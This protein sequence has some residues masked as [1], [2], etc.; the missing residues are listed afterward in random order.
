[1]GAA[2]KEVLKLVDVDKTYKMG[3]GV[4]VRA[5][6]KANMTIYDKELMCILG[7]SGSGKSTL[8][9][10]IGLL[11]SPTS[12]ERYIDGVETSTMSENEQARVRGSKIGF[13]FQTF[14]LINSLTVTD[15]V[16]LPLLICDTDCRNKESRVKGILTKVG[17][18]HRM[19]HYPNQLSGGERQRV[20]IARALVNDPE[21]ILADEPTGN[22]DSKTGAEVL[23]ILKELHKEGRTIAIITHDESITK[24]AERVVR[25]KDGTI[26]DWNHVDKKKTVKPRVRK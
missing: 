15:N 6:R 10:I 26:Y 2:R 8:L 3:E 19:D 13:V 21:I 7:P 14:N 23:K 25:L 5:L 16:K 11:D 22:L 1:M 20:A 17:L 4:T 18:G 12:G 24:I 9:H